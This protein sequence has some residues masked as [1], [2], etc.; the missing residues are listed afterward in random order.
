M[1]EM[2][3]CFS[4]LFRDE[5]HEAHGVGIV[6]GKEGEVLAGV[7]AL[8]RPRCRPTERTAALVEDDRACDRRGYRA[9]VRRY[10]ARVLFGLADDP[11]TEDDPDL[12]VGSL[13]R[14]RFEAGFLRGQCVKAIDVL[15]E[16][17]HQEQDAH[18]DERPHYEHGEQETLISGH[19]EK[20]RV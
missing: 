8:D 2:P 6:E 12:A 13:A 14:H 16:L 18:D 4:S 7:E 15:L 11:V 3:R 1:Y 10:H 20:C 9:W 17:A 5:L 19:G